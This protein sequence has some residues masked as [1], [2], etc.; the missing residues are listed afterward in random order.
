MVEKYHTT[1]RNMVCQTASGDLLRKDY[2]EGRLPRSGLLEPRQV[3]DRHKNGRQVMSESLGSS[4]GNSMAD[5]IYC[6]TEPPVGVTETQHLLLGPFNAI[7]FPPAGLAT[8]PA[9]GDLIWLVWRSS[10]TAVPLLL[11]G[12]RVATTADDRIRWTNATLPGVRPAAEA[13]GYGGPRNMTFLRLTGVVSP[14]GLPPANV[15]IIA[16]GLN[17]AS[18]QQV[19]VLTKLLPIL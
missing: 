9:Q 16:S 7:W 4:E 3:P 5:F 11:G 10:P 15:G 2:I 6:G 19:R 12:G 1:E 17:I 18:A 8:N 13:L 14:Q